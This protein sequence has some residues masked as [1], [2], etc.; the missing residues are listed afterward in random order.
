MPPAATIET[1]DGNDLWRATV[2]TI[3]PGDV[4]RAARHEPRR[5]GARRRRVVARR[6]DIRDSRHR[7]ASHRRRHAGRRRARHGDEGRRAGA[8][9]STPRRAERPPAPADEP[10]RRAADA[11][12]G[13]ELARGPGAVIL[14]GRF[15][16]VDER[17]IEAR[18]LEEVSLGDYVLSGGEIAALA[19]IDACVRLL[20]GVMGK[21]AS[22][23]EES[24]ARRPARI[25]AI[26][27]AAACSRA[28]PIPEVLTSGD[29]GKI[30]AWRRAEAERL[31]A[32]APAGP[33]GGLSGR[34][35]ALKTGAKSDGS[36][37]PTEPSCVQAR[38]PM[39]DHARPRAGALALP[40]ENSHEHHQAARTRSRSQSSP[41][42]RTSRNSSRA[43]P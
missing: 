19:L 31:T 41:P 25:S 6:V 18:Q 17:V 15:E 9:A 7:Q 37:R 3:F 21:E 22:G 1:K 35:K 40:T 38:Q 42:A 2:L 30:A 12:A 4:S 14:C 29:H 39:S 26:H 10:A 20:P 13:R 43:T 33:L 8:R 23:D 24:F 36:T 5:Q 16:G 28:A 32:S 34:Q 27:P 11:G